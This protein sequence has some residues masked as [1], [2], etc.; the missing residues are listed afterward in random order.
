ME[1]GENIV[2]PA[3]ALA[4]TQEKCCCSSPRRPGACNIQLPPWNEGFSCMK[5][6]AKL[7]IAHLQGGVG[8]GPAGRCAHVVSEWL[9]LRSVGE[10]GAIQ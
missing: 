2:L 1:A 4:R 6:S 9:Q 7:R 8:I 3:R 5:L 10:T